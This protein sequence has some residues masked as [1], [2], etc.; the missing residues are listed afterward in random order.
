MS[1]SPA[2][3]E[4]LRLENEQLR[5]ENEQLVETQRVAE[6]ARDLYL[7]S[8][9]S[10]PLPTLM[11]DSIGSITDANQAARRL[12]AGIADG[13]VTVHAVDHERR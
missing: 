2:A 3:P 12:L 4:Q 10:S 9:Q 6:D 13:A 5:L 11:L 7:D 1:H 8:F